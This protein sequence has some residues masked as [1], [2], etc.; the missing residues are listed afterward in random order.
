MRKVGSRCSVNANEMSGTLCVRL[1]ASPLLHG[2]RVQTEAARYKTVP[3]SAFLLN[4]TII[5]G[6]ETDW[7]PGHN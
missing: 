3:D 6:P 1:S 5:L 4:S 7:R 2:L